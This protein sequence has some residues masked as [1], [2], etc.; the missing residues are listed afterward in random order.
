[1]HFGKSL[2]KMPSSL[3]LDNETIAKDLDEE[4]LYRARS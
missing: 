4:D 1:M 2:N 3:L